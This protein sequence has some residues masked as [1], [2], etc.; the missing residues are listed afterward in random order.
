MALFARKKPVPEPVAEPPVEEP[1]P[2]RSPEEHLDAVLAGAAPLRPFGMQ[3]NDVS[4][5]TLCEDIA[6]DLDLPLVSTAIVE[7]YGVRAAN[8][9]G[10][11]ER[12]PIDLRILGVV[13]RPDELPSLAVPPGGCVLL[14]AGAPLPKGVDAVVPLADAARLGRSATFTFE[15]QVHQNVSLRGSDLA[16]GTPLLTSG[17]VLDARSIGV[18][19]EV[20]LDKVL[21]RPRP[22]LVVLSLGPDLIA[23]GLPVSAVNQRYASATPLVASAARADGA[24]VFPLDIVPRD[25]AA[26]RQTLGDQAIRADAMV[27]LTQDEADAHLLGHVLDDLGTVDLAHVQW[28]DGGALAVGRLG[29]ERLPVLGLPADPVAAYVGYHLFVRPLLAAL[30]ARTAAPAE[31]ATARLAEGVPAAVGVRYLP[32]ILDG[33]RVRPVTEGRARAHHLQAANALIVVPAGRPVAAGASVEYLPIAG[34]TASG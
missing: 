26:L 24:S 6:S 17:T 28:G 12:H 31:R 34:P 11:S 7:G 30:G 2:V 4:G 22:R 15:A 1:L 3:I 18:L 16:D 32:G 20:G 9:V 5:L 33:D 27:V 29:E 13:D 10:A 23:P 19:A 8:I 14:S 21:V 25:A